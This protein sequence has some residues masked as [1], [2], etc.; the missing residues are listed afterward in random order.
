MKFY[1]GDSLP[2]YGHSPG[3][4]SDLDVGD[5]VARECE[6]IG[7]LAG[8][9]LPGWV[10][11]ALDL[12]VEEV[13]V[14]EG[15]RHRLAFNVVLPGPVDGEAALDDACHDDVF[16]DVHV[17]ACFCRRLPCRD[18]EFENLL[19]DLFG[20]ILERHV[21]IYGT[22]LAVHGVSVQEY[23]AF[24]QTDGRGYDEFPVCARNTLNVE[25]HRN[26]GIGRG[27]YDLRFAD[28]FGRDF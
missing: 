16:H 13:F 22:S 8:Q 26:P 10:V 25:L 15:E 21:G 11:P 17:C 28:S 9:E 5:A 20:C 12:E 19:A 24:A 3:L 27:V 14:Y 7:R 4:E 2:G 18:L 1:P 23:L 6:R